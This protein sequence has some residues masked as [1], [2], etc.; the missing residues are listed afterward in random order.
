MKVLYCCWLLIP[1]HSGKS[2]KI[3]ITA[4]ASGFVLW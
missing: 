1:F 4:S 2:S 3:D